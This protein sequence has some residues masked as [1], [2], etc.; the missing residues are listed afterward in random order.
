MRDGTIFAEIHVPFIGFA[1]K[2]MFPDSL[3]Q[4][5][6]IMDPLSS[7]NELPIPL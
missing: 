6:K 2:F 4:Q 3:F 1:R 7:A 5:I